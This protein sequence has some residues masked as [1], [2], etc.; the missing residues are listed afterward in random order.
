VLTG[1]SISLLWTRWR[2]TRRAGVALVY[3]VFMAAVTTMWYCAV[4]TPVPLLPDGA[5]LSGTGR[6]SLCVRLCGCIL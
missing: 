1:Q 3:S 2:R 5:E 6:A 4:R